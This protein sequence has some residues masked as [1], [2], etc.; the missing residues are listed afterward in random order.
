MISFAASRRRRAEQDYVSP[1]RSNLNGAAAYI[2]LGQLSI[3]FYCQREP[4]SNSSSPQYWRP[5]A[6]SS[7]VSACFTSVSLSPPHNSLSLSLFI[8]K[9]VSRNH[10]PALRRFISLGY[11][12]AEWNMSISSH[13]FL[14]S[15]F[16]IRRNVS[17]DITSAG[18][19]AH[20]PF[21]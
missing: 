3:I 14:I 12:P 8:C 1:T 20:K 13:G 17:S 2:T 21:H 11:G 7:L 5:L 6:C 4:R 18:F 19:F 16:P 15:P 10:L 9:S